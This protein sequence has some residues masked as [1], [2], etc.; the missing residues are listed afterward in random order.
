M[1]LKFEYASDFGVN[2][3]QAY[4]FIP[5][6]TVSKE[7]HNTVNTFNASANMQIYADE[8]ARNRLKNG[9]QVREVGNCQLSFEYDLASEDNIVM[10]A[11]EYAKTL[12]E[13]S[14]A[15]DC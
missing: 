3:P 15:V 4:G 14:G 8:T 7:T 10:Q 11:Y 5:F 1:A 2:H 13:F 6:A 9:E 12:N